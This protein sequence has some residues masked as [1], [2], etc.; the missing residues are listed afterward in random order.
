MAFMYTAL[1]LIVI[2]LGQTISDYNEQMITL[3]KESCTWL[4]VIMTNGLWKIENLEN[5]KTYN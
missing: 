5:D 1:P 4:T 2:T 3:T